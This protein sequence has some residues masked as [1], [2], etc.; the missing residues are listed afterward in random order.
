MWGVLINVGM[1]LFSWAWPKLLMLFGI[2]AVSATVTGPLLS[3]LS[4]HITSS[5]NGMSGDVLSF[6]QYVGVPDAINIVMAAIT[7]KVSMRAA[8]VAFQKKAGSK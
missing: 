5:M 4:G 6:L 1:A 3:W 2:T 8:Q 7:L